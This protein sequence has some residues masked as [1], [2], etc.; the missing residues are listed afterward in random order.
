M[1]LAE[2]YGELD[3]SW[4][5]TQL[6]AVQVRILPFGPSHIRFSSTLL[7]EYAL[8]KAPKFD[9]PRQER[10][11]RALDRLK[12]KPPKSSDDALRVAAEITT[13]GIRLQRQA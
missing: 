5:K 9:L 2:C 1:W 8:K 11:Q 6:L 3:G 13:L 4:G 10:R 7:L 12:A